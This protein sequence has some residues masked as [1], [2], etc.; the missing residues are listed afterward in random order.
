MQFPFATVLAVLGACFAG[1]FEALL[2]VLRAGNRVTEFFTF[3]DLTTPVALLALIV[4]LR[5]ESAVQLMSLYCGVW[6]TVFAVALLYIRGV[7]TVFPSIFQVSL[8]RWMSLLRHTAG[9]IYGNFGSRLS[10]HI[11]VLV[12]ANIV[13]IVSVGEY[14]AA[15]QFAIGFMVVQHFVFL[16]LPWQLRRA[17]EAGEQG[18]G[19]VWVASQQRTLLLVAGSA[20]ILLWILAE[21]LLSLLGQRFVAVADI[22]RIFALIRF[23]DLLW[24]PNHEML[25]SNGYTV[26]DAHANIVAL[27]VWLLTFALERS[28]EIDYIAAAVVATA[29]ASLAA[30][31]TRYRVIRSAGLIPVM[32][33]GL[34]PCRPV[35]MTGSTVALAF[36]VL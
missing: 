18:P 28:L 2:A 36:A 26:Q 21:S 30:Q 16:S 15:A 3:R 5:P 6:A 20:F 29:L 34:G 14:R 24:G 7:V 27:L 32:G 1:M 33:H 10:I 11:D 4:L 22:F 13:S 8:R 25:V 23:V 19:H 9:L 31:I 35:V 12:L 17:S